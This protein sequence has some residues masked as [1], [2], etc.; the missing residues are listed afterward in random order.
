MLH[1]RAALVV[2][3]LPTIR[4]GP[5]AMI[6][7]LR[8]Q[9]PGIINLVSIIVRFTQPRSRSID[10]TDRISEGLSL[11]VNAARCQ[12]FFFEA[13][14]LI[15]NYPLELA[16]EECIIP[17]CRVCVVPVLRYPGFDVGSIGQYE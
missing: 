16:P 9:G 17:I 7:V 8:R 11:R 12:L 5:G 6:Q 4:Y 15:H 2:L 3:R 13:A 1:P 10:T 14:Y